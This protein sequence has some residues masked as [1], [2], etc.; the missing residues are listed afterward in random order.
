M[1]YEVIT[2]LV[3]GIPPAMGFGDVGVW[4]Y[5]ALVLLVIACPCA[6][7]LAAPVVT[8]TA[9]TRATRDGILVKGASHLETLGKVRSVAFDKTGTLTRG[10]L[11]VT[12]V[13]AAEG[14]TEND[15]IRMAG[16]SYNFV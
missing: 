14:V 16:A 15:V 12:R 1:L 3:G 10:K 5:R 7:V 6:I 11:R 8:V 13:V 9:L 2:L 4:A